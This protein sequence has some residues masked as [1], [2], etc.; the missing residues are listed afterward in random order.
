YTTLFRSEALVF[1]VSGE[2]VVVGESLCS[3]LLADGQRPVLALIDAQVRGRAHEV[4]VAAALRRECADRLVQR[5]GR[6]VVAQGHDERLAAVTLQSDGNPVTGRLHIGHVGAFE[7]VEPTVAEPV[8]A[9]ARVD[10]VSDTSGDRLDVGSAA[11]AGAYVVV[12]T[13]LAAVLADGEVGVLLPTLDAFDGPAG[14][15]HRIACRPQI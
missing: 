1:L 8:P 13:A 6:A 2:D 14:G 15:A 7:V 10:D 3:G 12:L 5:A 4:V 11:R 9:H